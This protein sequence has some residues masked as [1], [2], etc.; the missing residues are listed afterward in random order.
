LHCFLETLELHY[1]CIASS[2]FT[3]IGCSRFRDFAPRDSEELSVPLL[4]IP[5][6]ASP[7][8]LDRRSRFLQG[9]RSRSSLSF[10][11][12]SFCD[13]VALADDSFR[14]PNSPLSSSQ[15]H[16]STVQIS[17]STNGLDLLEHQCSILSRDF[18]TLGNNLLRASDSR[19]PRS[20]R[21]MS[22]EYLLH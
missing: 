17:S 4:P 10:C 5:E 15:N 20:Q 14:A 13:F 8:G 12:F 3:T 16:L 22:V 1:G 11:N 6:I 21:H 2:H 18:A 19:F 7:S 9:Q